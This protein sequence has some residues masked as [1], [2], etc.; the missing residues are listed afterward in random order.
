M[1][2]YLFDTESG[3]YLGQDFG[4]PSDI[5]YGEG[6]TELAPPHFTNGETPVFDFTTKQWT[7][8]EIDRVRP[9]FIQKNGRD[10]NES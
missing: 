2:L 5:N 7:V 1:K 8:V 4:A 9:V 6:I 10:S 3:L